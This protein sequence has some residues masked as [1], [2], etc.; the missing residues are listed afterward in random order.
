MLHTTLKYTPDTL[1][2]DLAVIV[3]KPCKEVRIPFMQMTHR[4]V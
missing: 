1:P 4:F 2:C 3:R